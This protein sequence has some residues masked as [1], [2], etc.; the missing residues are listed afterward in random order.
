MLRHDLLMSRLLL[1]IK[2]LSNQ[3]QRFLDRDDL[4][5]QYTS[6]LQSQYSVVC[7]SVPLM[8]AAVSQSLKAPDPI[9]AI[10]VPYLQQHIEEEADHDTWLLED[11]AYIGGGPSQIPSRIVSAMVGSQYYF[12]H[13]THPAVLL[14]YIFALESFPP[15]KRAVE[16]L[17]GTPGLDLRALRTVL[18]HSLEDPSHACDL[19]EVID[20]LPLSEAQETLLS[21]NAVLTVNYQTQELTRLM[22]G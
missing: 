16:S 10:L 5:Y 1:V 18:F 6:Y 7:A 22:D 8:Q 4:Q 2:D 3:M 15:P 13:H 14:G 17:Q 20:S 12:I 19:E 9:T 21:I 11:L